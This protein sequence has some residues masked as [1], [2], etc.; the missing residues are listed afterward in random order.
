MAHTLPPLPYALDALAPTISKE[1]LS[2]A[3]AHKDFDFKNPK[4]DL[5]AQ[6]AQSKPGAVK[7][8]ELFDFP[9]A[10]FVA[11]GPPT[12]VV[13]GLLDPRLMEHE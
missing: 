3:Y 12:L 11:E 1:T 9:G 7:D 8:F 5:F 6:T 10:G 13:H 2:T 4:T